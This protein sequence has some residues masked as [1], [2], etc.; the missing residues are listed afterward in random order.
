MRRRIIGWWS[1]GVTSAVACRLCL[2]LFDPEEVEII[3]ID[4][5]NEDEDTYRF[6]TDCEAWYG[7]HI[8]FITNPRFN[9]IEEVWLK[10]RT[11]NVANGAVCSSQL[12]TMVRRQWQQDNDYT[13]QAFGFDIDE[14]RRARAMAANHP[15]AKPIFPLLMYG[16]SKKECIK[17]V[18]SAGLEI[19]RMYRLG[20]HNNNCFRTGC[21]QGGIGYWQKICREYPDKFDR[22]AAMEHRLTDMKS[23]PVTMLRDRSGE[24]YTPMFLK[25]HPAY[26]HV[27]D[28]STAQGREVK[29]LIECN[30]FCGID[31]LMPINPTQ[32][33]LNFDSD[34]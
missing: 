28:I 34:D 4:T 9:S 32:Y 17:I 3:G 19:P 25:P 20:F 1:G 24:R 33:E 30:G 12:K 5:H 11:L 2:D 21:V 10:Y 8:T 15:D 14:C 26:P 6:K 13:S 29:P 27:K 7:K 16:L 18:E 31:D 22:M 23:R